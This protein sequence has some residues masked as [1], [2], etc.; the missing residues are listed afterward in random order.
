MPMI[1]T[2][3]LWYELCRS[4]RCL[5]CQ[6]RQRDLWYMCGMWQ[7]P[8][9]FVSAVYSQSRDLFC[10]WKCTIIL[11]NGRWPDLFAVVLIV[12]FWKPE[13][14]PW[15]CILYTGL[16][17]LPYVV[18]GIWN[19]ETAVLEMGIGCEEADKQGGCNNSFTLV[20][21]HYHCCYTVAGMLW[22]NQTVQG[23]MFWWD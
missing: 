1:F 2:M 16:K 12:D 3:A 10:L 6:S 11:N 18:Y 19:C 14:D 15:T 17:S 21:F 9:E 4:L 5:Y 7:C 8:E 13:V 20:L 23:Q 22:W